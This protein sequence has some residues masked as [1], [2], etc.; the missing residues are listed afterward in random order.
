MVMAGFDPSGLIEKSSG[1]VYFLDAAGRQGLIEPALPPNKVAELQPNRRRVLPK[2]IS[3]DRKEREYRL[4]EAEARNVKVRLKK[5][6]VGPECVHCGS[7]FEPAF[8]TGGCYGICQNC[9][10][11]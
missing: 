7:P 11:G 4:M 5:P 10:D 3:E 6:T 1:L 8:F 9:I 2:T